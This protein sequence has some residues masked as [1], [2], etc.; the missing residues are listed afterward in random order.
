MYAS[1][2]LAMRRASDILERMPTLYLALMRA[3][4]RNSGFR[5][6]IVG[7]DHDVMIEGYPRSAN[8]FAHDAFAM[9]NPGL[10][11]ATHLHSAAHVRMAV[12]CGVPAMVLVREPDAAV[13]SSLALMS[14][15]S[16]ATFNAG[17]RRR[18]VRE[19]TLRYA[20]F[21]ERL[22]PVRERVL[23]IRFE[24]AITDFGVVVER[25]NA[26]AGTTFTRFEHTEANVARITASAGFHLAPNAERD[27]MKHL[28]KEAYFARANAAARQRA[29]AAC[30]DT[31][32]AID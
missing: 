29:N 25:L 22:V 8:S 2:R 3:R 32:A 12:A 10:A 7:P 16:G 27:S 19:A 6:S 13:L 30:E 17:A 20:R 28:W 4:Y 14:Q 11:I 26:R 24:D 1:R 5:R 23:L 18:L 21:Y 9:A 15:A 31:R